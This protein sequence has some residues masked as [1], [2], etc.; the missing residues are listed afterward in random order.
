MMDFNLDFISHRKK[1]PAKQAHKKAYTPQHVNELADRLIALCNVKYHIA[2]RAA[3]CRIQF[4]HSLRVHKL[5][6]FEQYVLRRKQISFLAIKRY[7]CLSSKEQQLSDKNR[8]NLP[9]AIIKKV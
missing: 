9:L 5:E 2:L 3:F 6:M 4:G 8:L 1:P 7:I